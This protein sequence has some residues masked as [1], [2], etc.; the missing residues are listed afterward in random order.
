MFMS[1]FIISQKRETML[2][3]ASEINQSILVVDDDKSILQ[4][5][6]KILQ[7]AGCSVAAVETGRQ[8]IRKLET[9][10]YDVAIIDVRLQD[11]NG[12]D[13]LNRIQTIAPKMV[14]IILTGSPSDEDRSRALEQGAD[15]YLSKPIKLEQLIEIIESASKKCSQPVREDND[16]PT[17]NHIV[18]KP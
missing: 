10:T 5:L 9:Q 16:A 8:A 12:L 14:K 2:R 4:I 17:N 13:L 15:Y 3:K 1:E 6:A 7:K 11:I 18:S